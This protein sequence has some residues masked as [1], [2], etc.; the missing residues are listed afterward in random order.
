M[1]IIHKLIVKSFS[2][3][4]KVKDL[5]EWTCAASRGVRH[6]QERQALTQ[7]EGQMSQDASEDIMLQLRSQPHM[8]VRESG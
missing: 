2:I 8:Q 5:R 1:H 4:G 7:L 3:T 6:W